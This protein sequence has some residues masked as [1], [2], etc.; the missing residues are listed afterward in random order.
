MRKHREVGGNGGAREWEVQEK[1]DV[2]GNR[3]DINIYIY[4]I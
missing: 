4:S 3:D 1:K 2:T